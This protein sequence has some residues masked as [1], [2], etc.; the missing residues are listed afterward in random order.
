MSLVDSS[1]DDDEDMGTGDAAGRP[2]SK[3][4]IVS[5]YQGVHIPV[6]GLSLVAT[7]GAPGVGLMVLLKNFLLTFTELNFLAGAAEPAMRGGV[8]VRD[9]GDGARRWI[10]YVEG[11]REL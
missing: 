8:E 6:R 11:D 10:S 2:A 3:V 5:H 9:A 7:A 1:R 4:S